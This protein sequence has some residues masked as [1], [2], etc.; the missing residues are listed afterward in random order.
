MTNELKRGTRDTIQGTRICRGFRRIMLKTNH[1]NFEN[2]GGSDYEIGNGTKV[3]G[4]RDPIRVK[5]VVGL[6]RRDTRC[7]IRAGVG[8]KTG[9]AVVD[10]GWPL[11]H[12]VCGETHGGFDFCLI[13]EMVKP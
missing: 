1:I 3:V 8:E 4:L 10:A 9:G 11:H 5:V 6:K 13:F 2:I 12:L 7:E